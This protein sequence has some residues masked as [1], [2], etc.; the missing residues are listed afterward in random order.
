MKKSNFSSLFFFVFLFLLLAFLNFRVFN[1]KRKIEEKINT[2]SAKI[3]EL[4][5]KK[6]YF[7]KEL[8]KIEKGTF[9]EEKGRSQGYIKEGEE[10]I[11][12]QFK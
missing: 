1:E 7:E 9:W 2:L 11:I 4:K 3:K 8:Q 5:E 6:A 10:E 12:I